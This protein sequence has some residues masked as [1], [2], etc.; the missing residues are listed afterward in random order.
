MS[1]SADFSYVGNL[2]SVR[3]GKFVF[4]PKTNLDGLKPLLLMKEFLA[5][6]AYERTVS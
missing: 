1:G 3:F 2:L 4:H 5:H 6:R